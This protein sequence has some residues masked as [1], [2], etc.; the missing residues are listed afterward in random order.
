MIEHKR[1]NSYK[2]LK[3][4]NSLQFRILGISIILVTSLTLS[5]VFIYTF[6]L[7]NNLMNFMRAEMLTLCKSSSQSISIALGNNDLGAI[8]EV[9][10][11]LKSSQELEKIIFKDENDFILVSF[12]EESAPEQGSSQTSLSDEENDYLTVTEPVNVDGN[13]FGYLSITRSLEPIYS[14]QRDSW[15]TAVIIGGIGMLLGIFM[16]VRLSR[17]IINPLKKMKEAAAQVAASDYT[18]R[19]EFSGNDEV[20]ELVESFNLMVKKVSERAAKNNED[21]RIIN[22]KLHELARFPDENPGPIMRVSGEGVL[23]YANRASRQL[24]KFWNCKVNELFPNNWKKFVKSAL[25]KQEITDVT[26]QSEGRTYLLVFSPFTSSGYVNIYGNDISKL[27]KIEENERKL[28]SELV[29]AERMKSLGLLAGGVAHDLN[30]MLGPLVGYPELILRK[31]P[32]DSPFRDQI[33]RIGSSARDAA[34][35][36]Q[37]LLTLARRGR[38]EMVVTDLNK[39]ITEYL[40]SPGFEKIKEENPEL[41]LVI[42]LEKKAQLIKGS[43]PHLAKVVMNLVV[44]AVD[45]MSGN[46]TLT[47]NT[48][49]LDLD[50]LVSGYSSINACEYVVFKVQDTGHGIES[51]D[52]KKIFEPYYSKKTM[53]GSRGSGLGLSVVYGILQDHGGYYDVFSEVGKGTEFVL[54]FPVTSESQEFKDVSEILPEGDETILVV[55][56]DA[57]QRE[58]IQ[59]VLS[60]FGYE[61]TT[62]KNGTEAVKII[63]SQSFDLVVLDM[64]MEPGFDGLDTYKRIIELSPGQKAIIVSGFSASSRL[65]EVL[66]LEVGQLV[67]KPFELKHLATAVRSELDKQEAGVTASF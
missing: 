47:I 26:V 28:Q 20:T 34:S 38:Y 37:D 30:N 43:S 49:I 67:K 17:A 29:K 55:D 64:I 19:M 6:K 44:N 56:D 51:E 66:N 3:G 57:G 25:V 39:V 23:V 63:E 40:D 9:A 45:A 61:V 42:D 22:E 1:A 54:Y 53:Q 32:D 12:P 10:A 31:L 21:L 60:T 5:G 15:L 16:S 58:L 50:K 4:F 62:V 14:Q 35:V 59:Q 33:K 46:G 2:F 36:I 11:W 52:I 27:K 13:L 24:L 48:K 8:S 65:E 18:D 7:N 41:N